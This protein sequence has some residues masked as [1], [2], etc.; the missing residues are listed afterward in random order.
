MK[1][2]TKKIY[3]LVITLFLV[4]FLT[5]IAF[6]VIPGDS[7]ITSLGTNATEE[8]ILA[9]REE[10]GLNENIVV[11]FFT[12]A[13]NTLQGDF[14]KSFQYE[15]PVKTLVGDRLPV[16]LW[17][18]LLSILMILMVSIPLGILTARREGGFLDR[19]ITLITNTSMAIPPFF[20]GMLITLIFGF[21]LKWFTPGKYVSPSEHFGQF[22]N[23]LIFPA[24]AIAIPKIAMIVKFLRSSVLRQLK[25]DYVRTARSK[26]HKENTILYGHVLKNALIPVITF[27]AMVIADIMAGSIIVEQVFG[28]P[29]IGR[30]LVTSI[31]NRDYPVVQIIILYIAAIVVTIN[32]IV[33]IIYQYIDPRVKV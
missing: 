18:S 12:W 25:Q 5:F 33:D 4:S 22:L 10:L 13:G 9:L 17:L 8:A 7:A 3:T 28:L 27:M 24:L 14:G 23:Y 21:V 15:L 30:L 32:F 20:L 31:S 2:I 19:M 16:T 29:G 6:Q 11:R 1:Y 26:G